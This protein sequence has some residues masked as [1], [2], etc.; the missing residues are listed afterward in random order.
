MKKINTYCASLSAALSTWQ[1]CT[2][3]IGREMK[4][5]E[6]KVRLITEKAH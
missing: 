5:K 3:R 2:L 6:K 4:E 1:V